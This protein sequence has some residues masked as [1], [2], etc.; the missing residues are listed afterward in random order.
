VK[1]GESDRCP[2]VIQKVVLFPVVDIIAVITGDATRLQ[3]PQWSPP[4]VVPPKPSSARVAWPESP[5]SSWSVKVVGVGEKTRM[6]DAV[7]AAIFRLVSTL[8][9][10]IAALAILIWVPNQQVQVLAIGLAGAAILSLE[11][12]LKNREL[13]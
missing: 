11:E 2:V 3:R 13:G 1:K 5:G 8:L 12:F 10:L 7:R 6:S 4:K 9:V